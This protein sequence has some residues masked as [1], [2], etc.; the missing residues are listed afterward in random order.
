MQTITCIFFVSKLCKSTIFRWSKFSIDLLLNPAVSFICLE[1][2]VAW[3]FKFLN[4]HFNSMLIWIKIQK[5]RWVT[6]VWRL[7]QPKGVIFFHKNKFRFAIFFE[8]QFERKNNGNVKCNM[9]TL[10]RWIDSK[11]K[12]NAMVV[13]SNYRIWKSRVQWLVT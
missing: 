11:E 10:L 12:Y 3:N 8:N 7:M 6:V 5:I 2:A 13:L 4:F 9:T 1:D